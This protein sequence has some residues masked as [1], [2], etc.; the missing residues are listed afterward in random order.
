[1]KFLAKVLLASAAVCFSS[2]S[3][4]D[5]IQDL[6]MNLYQAG[7]YPN[8]I[9]GIGPLTC[10]RTCDIWVN[11][12]PERE[13]SSIV[14]PDSQQA[15]V[16]KITR[17]VSIIVEGVNDPTSHWIYGNQFDSEAVCHVAHRANWVERSEYYMCLCVRPST[18]PQ[19]L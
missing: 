16:C 6:S 8:F 1:M 17:D 3:S 12:R 18:L 14:D 10:V 4:A 11:S 5:P 9:Q 13:N 19:P 15:A 2:M 7:W